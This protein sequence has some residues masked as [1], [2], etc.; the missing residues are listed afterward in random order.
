M[1]PV[2]GVLCVVKGGIVRDYDKLKILM[3]LLDSIRERLT[4]LGVRPAG[5]VVAV[6]GGADSVALLRALA[7]L[8]DET[9]GPFVI[10]HLNHCL[11]GEESDGD[12]EFIRQLHA[13]LNAGEAKRFELAVARRDVAAIASETGGNLE[14][15]ARNQRYRWLAEVAEQYGVS[16]VATGHTADDQA[17]T[18]LH[19]LLRGTGL[20]GLRGI[21]S[22]RELRP[23]IDLIRPMLSSTR[24]D[25]LAFL[26]DIGQP[27]REDRTN[28]DLT[29]TRNRIRRQLL[30]LLAADYSPA[31]VPLLGSL[32]E[33]ASEVFA[34][35]QQRA[36]ELLRNS[37]LPP[38]GPL[39]ILDTARL[40]SAPRH[41]IREAMRLLWHREG[42]PLDRIRF[43]DWDRLAAVIAGEER[44][45]D[46][47]G[48]IRAVRHG[49]VVQIGPVG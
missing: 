28:S 48:P 43:Q 46:F 42:W 11:R 47:P 39:R 12:E 3:A 21:A 38:A 5:L 44:A 30:P 16:R 25:V 9:P 36:E 27:F 20:Q 23:G 13:E 29:L 7:M 32:A 14:A 24:A 35:L 41:L 1:M 6:S 19:R 10:A 45:V 33:Q 49:R 31:I 34:E 4:R 26:R 2:S 15:T 18:I 40:S 17:E 22:R 8:R 37:E